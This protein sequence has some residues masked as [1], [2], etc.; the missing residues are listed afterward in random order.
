[1]NSRRK[2]LQNSSALLGGT[3]LA[4]SVSN[5]AF[6]IFKNT[7]APSDQ[8]NIAAI[9]VNGMGWADVTAALKVP[10]VNLV[11]ICDIDKN[12]IEKRLNDLTKMGK[13]ASK[14]KTY[15]DYKKLLEN[16]DVDA[17]VVGTPDHWHALIMMDACAAGKD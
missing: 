3:I 16:K 4:S 10:G 1:M 9:G 6:A 2:F 15:G 17:V 5:S 8:L 13:D 14:V 7:V 11:A 12:V